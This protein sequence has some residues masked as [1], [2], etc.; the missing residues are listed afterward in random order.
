MSDE[1]DDNLIILISV[2]SGRRDAL[3]GTRSSDL[4]AV[5]PR[6]YWPSTWEWGVAAAGRA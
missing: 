1:S 6:R 5:E 4:A 3:A 2:A